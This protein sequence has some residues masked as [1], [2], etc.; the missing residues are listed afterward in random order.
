MIVKK[1]SMS[2]VNLTTIG[3]LAVEIL[4]KLQWLGAINDKENW[5]IM[6]VE[7][8]QLTHLCQW[9]L[10]ILSLFWLYLYEQSIFQKIFERKMW[11][12]TKSTTQIFCHFVLYSY[13]IVKGTT[14]PRI[15]M[16]MD[17]LISIYGMVLTSR[18]N[19]GCFGA[20]RF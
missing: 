11:F 14:G 3:Y 19:T 12:R 17:E 9:C 15:S 5:N 18:W 13:I 1:Y 6:V 7:K 2:L 10:K 8:G 20:M 16:N 4:L